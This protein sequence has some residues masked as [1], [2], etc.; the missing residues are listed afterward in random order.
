MKLFDKYKESFKWAVITDKPLE[1]NI[2]K[3][4]GLYYKRRV[5]DSGRELA[6]D[7]RTYND[8][9][10]ALHKA[11]SNGY[12]YIL[13][14][15][16]GILI[17]NQPKFY[18][19][20]LKFLDEVNSRGSWL[21]CGHII[22]DTNSFKFWNP[23]KDTMK[24]YYLWP[25][26][27]FVNLKKWR[28]LGCPNFGD[29]SEINLNQLPNVV[30]SESNVHDNYTPNWIKCGKDQNKDHVSEV[31]FGW[32][33]LRASVENNLTVY[34]ISNEIRNSQIYTYPE[35]NID[36]YN[37]TMHHLQ[38]AN[39]SDL[40]AVLLH[41]MD[42]MAHRGAGFNAFN[43]EP[44]DSMEFYNYTD[45]YAKID[46]VVNTCQGFKDFIFTFSNLCKD[47]HPV[48][49]IHYDISPQVVNAR[50][51]LIELWDGSL[52]SLVTNDL[53]NPAENYSAAYTR[54]LNYFDSKDHL[55]EQWAKYKKCQHYFV[56]QNL[57]HEA[58]EHQIKNLIKSAN[59]KNVM[60]FYSDIFPW[61]HN[62]LIYG[63][64]NLKKL[65]TKLLEHLKKDIDLLITESKGVD[66]HHPTFHII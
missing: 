65:Q 60:F 50:Q 66:D 51:K 33:M 1:E 34:N 55:L 31:R 32:N 4:F 64:E 40:D 56:V 63:Y 24:W 43:S 5:P 20:A 16:E 36:R 29:K 11:S 45:N 48:T 47:Q 27:C 39:F 19:N 8:P 21:V 18:F 13:L 2:K 9:M 35:N 12:D 57:F 23:G 14:N 3:S 61:E 26:T 37:R 38:S 46:T 54:L 58:E 49:F 17:P 53:V 41:H 10:E 6:D 15:W 62:Y 7:P 59:G 44:A 52:E 30:R 22:D 28:E 42:N 25:I